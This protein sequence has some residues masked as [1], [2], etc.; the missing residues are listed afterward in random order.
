M[1]A[2]LSVSIERLFAILSRSQPIGALK[3]AD[4]IGVVFIANLTADIRDR[5]VCT[6]QQ[7]LCH[8]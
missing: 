7:I 5:K 4:K 2:I 3:N 8:M 6:A 1:K